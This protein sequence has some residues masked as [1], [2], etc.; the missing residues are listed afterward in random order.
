MD[1]E[2]IRQQIRNY[3]YIIPGIDLQSNYTH[4]YDN[5]DPSTFRYCTEN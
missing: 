4:Y 2:T 3:C 1:N 5:K